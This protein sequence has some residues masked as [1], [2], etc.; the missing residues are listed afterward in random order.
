MSVRAEHSNFRPPP[1]EQEEDYRER[2]PKV[3]SSNDKITTSNLKQVCSNFPSL[4]HDTDG[5]KA[6]L[7]PCREKAF[8]MQLIWRGRRTPVYIRHDRN[9]RP[10]RSNVD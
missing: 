4:L 10:E 9:C 6:D 1:A 7:F 2:N 5:Q 3:I 8:Q